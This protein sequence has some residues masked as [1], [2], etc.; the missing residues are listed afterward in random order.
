MWSHY[1][2][3]HQGFCVGFDETAL[4]RLEGIIGQGP[5]RY[6]VD[7]PMFRYYFDP[8]ELLEKQVFACKSKLWKYEREYRIVFNRSGTVG[9]PKAA[10]KQIIIGCR[11]YMELRAYADHHCEKAEIEFF[12][13][14]ED[15]RAYRLRKEV[16][17]KNVTIM[18]SFF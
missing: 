8:P 16:V 12:Q 7:A 13:M 15:F 2:S 3:Q 9:F 17:R 10:L 5:V 4:A 6:Q 11:A 14:C 1:A 18:S